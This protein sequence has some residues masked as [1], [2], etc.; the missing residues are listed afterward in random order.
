LPALAAAQVCPS[1][2]SQ[3]IIANKTYVGRSLA[4]KFS[5]AYPIVLLS[6]NSTSYDLIVSEIKEAGGQ[7]VGVDAD[8]ADSV[9]LSN[10]FEKIKAEMG[11][12]K[13]AAAVYNVGGGFVRKP[14]LEL[15]EKEYKAGFESN[16]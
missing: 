6:R 14:F 12:R 5:A 13:L 2:H 8:V 7:A 1:H 15:T 16:G 10:A 11:D 4:L 9:S 3:K